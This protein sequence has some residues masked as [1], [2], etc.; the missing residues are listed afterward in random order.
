[1]GSL[2]GV[3]SMVPLW[4][5]MG[6]STVFLVDS[7]DDWGLRQCSLSSLEDGN[8]REKPMYYKPSILEYVVRILSLWIRVI[9][10]DDDEK[11]QRLACISKW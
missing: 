1:M 7:F 3:L 11:R 2:L 5:L 8:L 4:V 10:C 6:F 9:K